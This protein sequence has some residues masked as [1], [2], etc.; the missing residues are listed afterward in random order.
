MSFQIAG[1][2]SIYDF[3]NQSFCG[4]SDINDIRQRLIECISLIPCKKRS[5]D[6]AVWSHVPQCGPRYSLFVICGDL[7]DAFMDKVNE[8]TKEYAKKGIELSLC[9]MPVRSTN[10]E[11]AQFKG[12]IFFSTLFTDKRRKIR[13]IA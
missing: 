5:E 11:Y 12:E 6:Y 1:Q 13:K 4:D 8:I 10:P 7:T 2:M 9:Q 3:L